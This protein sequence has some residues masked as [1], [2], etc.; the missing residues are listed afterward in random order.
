MVEEQ[1]NTINQLNR[2][3]SDLEDKIHILEQHTTKKK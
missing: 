1:R 2:E 3:K